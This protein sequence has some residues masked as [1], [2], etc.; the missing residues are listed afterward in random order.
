MTRLAILL[1][2]LCS[3]ADRTA[4]DRDWREQHRQQLRS[5]CVE[6]CGGAF[7]WCL[8]KRPHSPGACSEQFADCERGC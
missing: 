1:L 3:C 8:T 5:A 7:N 6:Q 4:L 2:L